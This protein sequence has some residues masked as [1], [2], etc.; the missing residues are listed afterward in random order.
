MPVSNGKWEA[1]VFIPEFSSPGSA[2]A[3]SIDATSPSGAAHGYRSDLPSASEA[4][5][6]EGLDP[7]PPAIT[8]MYVDCPD[9]TEGGETGPDIIVAARISVPPTG[10]NIN[11]APLA[12]PTRIILDGSD[13]RS[14]IS[15]YMTVDPADGSLLLSMPYSSLAEG[16]HS[17]T[18]SAANNLGTATQRTIGFTVRAAAGHASIAVEERPARTSATFS[19]EH[20]LGDG[21]E[22]L[23]IIEDH[24]GSTVRSQ[25][26]LAGWDLTDNEGRPVASGV[27]RAYALLRNGLRRAAT[28]AV[29]VIVLRNK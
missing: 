4:A 11:T 18:L 13:T 6:T 23:L 7:A 26:S 1:S 22:G 25:S 19:V 5:S 9:F 28:G 21:T 24:T 16:R 14:N 12:G 2:Y 3:V 8:E 15:G 10:V 20:D 17:V 29:E 27:Y